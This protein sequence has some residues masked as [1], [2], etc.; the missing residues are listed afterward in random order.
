VVANEDI[1]MKHARTLPIALG[2]LALLGG[3]GGGGADGGQT[4]TVAGAPDAVAKFVG[5]QRER[6]PDLH[7][8]AIESRPG[9]D[10]QARLSLPRDYGADDLGRITRA[11]AAAG[12]SYELQIA[13]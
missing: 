1:A 2:A 13:N 9:G 11:A 7:S 5:D 6:E 3:C 12:L 8:V 4:L 10:A